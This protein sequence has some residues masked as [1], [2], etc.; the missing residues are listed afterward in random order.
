MCS[1]ISKKCSNFASHFGG[2]GESGRASK[3]QLVV[4]LSV[5]L[6]TCIA[7]SRVLALGAG[8][9]RSVCFYGFGLV[10]FVFV[11]FCVVVRL[12]VVPVRGSFLSFSFWFRCAV[13]V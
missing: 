10:C 6:W 7:S 3:K 11:G 4:P 2:F 8:S 13:S 1:K 9:L 5:V 12:V